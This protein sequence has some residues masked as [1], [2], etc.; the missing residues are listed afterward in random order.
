MTDL[1]FNYRLSDFQCALGRSQLKKLT[2]SNRA[3][4]S[5]APTTTASPAIPLWN[6]HPSA[7]AYRHAWPSLSAPLADWK[8]STK[9]A[10][11]FFANCGARG[12]GAPCAL[13]PIHLHT[14]YQ[15]LGYKK[16]SLPHAETFF[17]DCY[18]S[19]GMPGSP[20]GRWRMSNLKSMM[21]WRKCM[22]G[23]LN[24]HS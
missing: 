16:G 9:R 19:D 18:D 6:F 10:T 2:I 7:R 1:G 4:K 20:D 17:L 21:F 14:Y 12:I 24:A 15:Q 5:R 3:K 23:A 13:S 8:N 11:K 22:S